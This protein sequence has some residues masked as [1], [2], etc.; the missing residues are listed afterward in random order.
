MLSPQAHHYLRS[1]MSAFATLSGIPKG[2]QSVLVRPCIKA[3]VYVETWVILIYILSIHEARD[4]QCVLKEA[5]LRLWP[6]NVQIG[7]FVGQVIPMLRCLPD[8]GAVV[9]TY[10]LSTLGDRESGIAK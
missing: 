10:D 4:F 6:K 8:L 3:L 9:H 5:T 7:P 1:E 2:I